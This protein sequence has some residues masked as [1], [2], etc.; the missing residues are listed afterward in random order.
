LASTG[1][2]RRPALPAG[3]SAVDQLAAAVDLRIDLAGAAAPGH[4][5]AAVDG[6]LDRLGGVDL[7][8]AAAVDAHLHFVGGQLAEIGVAGALDHQMQLGGPYVGDDV[9]G[10][11]DLHAQLVAGIV[12][13]A[14]VAAA[15][16][17]Q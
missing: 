17:A 5:A 6:G 1:P 2:S 12:V 8:V 14:H 7:G 9:A 3:G 13:D 11:L 10:T 4:V 16:Q 15:L